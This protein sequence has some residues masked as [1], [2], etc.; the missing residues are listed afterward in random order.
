MP[1]Y[2][3]PNRKGGDE[4]KIQLSFDGDRI[5]TPWLKVLGPRAPA[6]PVLVIELTRSG[7]ALVA[8]R[9]TVESLPPQSAEGER[10]KKEFED[11]TAWPKHLPVSLHSC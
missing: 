11:E 10:V 3:P 5:V 1:L 8:A 2:K 4:Y 6:A 7:D 9:G